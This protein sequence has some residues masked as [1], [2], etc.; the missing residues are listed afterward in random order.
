MTNYRKSLSSIT[1][2][3]ETRSRWYSENYEVPVGRY[4]SQL[5]FSVPPSKKLKCYIKL[6]GT[7]KYG[8]TYLLWSILLTHVRPDVCF[9]A[10]RIPSSNLPNTDPDLMV[11]KFSLTTIR[12]M[13]TSS[14]WRKIYVDDVGSRH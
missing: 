6:E 9:A 1:F 7:V 13:S 10:S 12:S 4:V 11:R 5:I 2:P 8:S 14:G 3:G